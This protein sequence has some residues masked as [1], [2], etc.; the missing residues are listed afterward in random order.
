MGEAVRLA[1]PDADAV[2]VRRRL[3]RSVAALDRMV[4]EGWFDSEADTC[5]FE[6]ELDLVDPLGRPRQVNG[7]VLAAMGRADVQV[8]LSRFNLELNL[9]ARPT[10][11]RVLHGLATELADTLD[12]VTATAQPWGARTVAIGTL[13]TLHADDLTARDIS[14]NPRYPVLEAAMAAERRGK[15]RLDIS[16]RERLRLTTD[17]IAVQGAATSLQVHLR[18]TAS[19]F[20]RY[21]N[22]A[23]RVAP[24]QVAVG[25]NAPFLLGRHLWHETRIA[26]ITQSLDVRPVPRAA[27]QPPRVW[28]GDR[29]VTSAVDLF[30]DNVRRYAP[31][32]PLLEPEDPLD[33]LDGGRVPSLHELRLHNG[34]IWRWNR[35]VYD[36]QHGRPHLRIENRV[37]PSGP[38][39]ADMAANAAFY[40]G[41]VRALADRGDDPPLTP[42]DVVGRDLVA[43]A[44]Y[45]LD[46]RLHAPDRRGRTGT[47]RRLVLDTLLPLAADGLDAWGVDPADRDHY[48]GVLDARVTSGRTGAHWQVAA[49][50]ALEERGR[51]REAALRETVRL[52]A[53]HAHTRAPVHTWPVP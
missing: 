7:A 15:V 30:D 38:T 6:V 40:L 27:D 2:A 22:A 3:D 13:P 42:F 21:Y 34:T 12:A 4:A 39:A 43:A 32:L 24:A 19:D 11:G 44:R 17:S 48:L 45:G 28:A 37:L 53:D 52:Y 8:E 9:A 10:R 47:A 26:L 51:A 33:A 18:V 31:L 41:L 20:A 14:A 16:G 46:A 49:V 35:P 5:G 23:Q 1:G 29:W 25:A 36:V 50:A